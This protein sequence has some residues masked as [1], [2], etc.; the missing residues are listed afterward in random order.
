MGETAARSIADIIAAKKRTT[1]TATIV[2]DDETGDEATFTFGSLTRVEYRDLL[3]KHK[4][5]GEQR[6]EFREAQKL[7]GIP[8]HRRLELSYNVDTY[9]PAL[10]AACAVDPAMTEVEATELWNVLGNGEAAALFDTAQQVNLQQQRP[11][12]PEA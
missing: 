12:D 3:D 4:P 5:T 8:S 2:L 7:A 10:I 11:P 1:R 9:P 6:R